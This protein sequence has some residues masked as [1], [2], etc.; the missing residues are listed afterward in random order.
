MKAVIAFDAWCVLYSS[1]KGNFRWRC[2]TGGGKSWR[3][4]TYMGWKFDGPFSPI[5]LLLEIVVVV[6]M[7]WNPT[8]STRYS[9]R[10]PCCG[11]NGSH[12]FQGPNGGYVLSLPIA[13]IDHVKVEGQV[14]GEKMV[15]K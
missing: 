5:I 15:M 4:P 3:K 9:D 14:R 8:A 11:A 6:V 2:D 13:G 1:M 10:S 12:D 7:R